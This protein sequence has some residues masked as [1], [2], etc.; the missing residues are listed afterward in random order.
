MER[1]MK[2]KKQKNQGI[3]LVVLVVTIVVMLILAGT[4]IKVASD[5]GL[6]KYA[7]KANEEEEKT[8]ETN[9]LVEIVIMLKETDKFEQSGLEKA[10]DKRFGQGK[11]QVADLGTRFEVEF[12]G[13][14]RYYIIDKKGNVSKPQEVVIDKNAGDITK[15]GTLDGS[16]EKPYEI[17]C[18]ED[19]VAF[20][21]M[22]NGKGK[23]IVNGI[24]ENIAKSVDF[25]GKYVVLTKDL[26][27]KSKF[28][29]ANSER[30]DFGDINGDDTDGNALITE[31]TTGQGFSAIGFKGGVFDGQNHAVEELYI[32]NEISTTQGGNGLFGTVN[33]VKIKNL[34]VTGKIHSEKLPTGGI[35]G[36]TYGETVIDNCHNQ[37]FINSK[38]ASGGI[39]GTNQN[40]NLLITNCRNTGNIII[41]SDAGSYSSVGRN[42]RKWNKFS[43]YY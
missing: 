17:S 33:T 13:K 18:I 38:I 14:N 28:S 25:T 32:S 1:N 6:F 20:S 41:V 22:G 29:Y 9:G 8:S 34:T 35:A 4:A 3:T 5:A 43:H 40:G 7:K 21:N 42:I 19:L 2:I 27:F 12:I 16:A 23:K 39:A 10:V 30:T 37:V 36:R 15:G 24:A 26:N 31:M 11:V